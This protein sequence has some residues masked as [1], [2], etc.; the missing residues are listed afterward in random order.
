VNLA[1]KVKKEKDL[2]AYRY[3]TMTKKN[4]VPVRLASYDTPTPKPKTYEYDP[5][6]DPQPQP[7]L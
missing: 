7:D 5:H 4:V 1:R 3:E 6:L 2:K